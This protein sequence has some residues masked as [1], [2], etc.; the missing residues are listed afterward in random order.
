MNKGQIWET[1]IEQRLQLAGILRRLDPGQWATPSLCVGWTVQDVAAHMISAPQLGPAAI[2][3][4]MPQ[5]L[6][7]GYNGTTLHDGQRR[8][9]AGAASILSQF[10]RFATV[11]R[12]PAVVSMRETLTDSLVHFQDIVRPLSIEHDMPLDAAVEVARRLAH[13]GL[14]LGSRPML[15]SLRMVA[16]DADYSQG[17]GDEISGPIAE[18]VMLRAGRAPRWELL[19]G[20][21]FDVAREKWLARRPSET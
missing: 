7:Y 2:L 15:T 4:L 20:P 9:R 6:R 17:S 19:Q 12:G 10:D 8:G 13:T 16:T 1:V 21:G 18:L 11:P 3:K 14:L 5:M